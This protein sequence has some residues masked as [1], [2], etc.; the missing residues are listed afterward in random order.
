MAASQQKGSKLGGG[1]VGN[2]PGL[3]H[4]ALL[5]EDT[6]GGGQ[7]VAGLRGPPEHPAD[8]HGRQQLADHGG[9]AGDASRR[10]WAA[11]NGQLLNHH[12]GETPQGGPGGQ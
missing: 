1:A 11:S 7:H 3:G 10:P 6:F 4:P 5:E 12:G 8:S 9:R 2:T